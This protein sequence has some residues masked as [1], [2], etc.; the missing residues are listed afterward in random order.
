MSKAAKKNNVVQLRTPD[1]DLVY[2][3]AY[4]SWQAVDTMI[5]RLSGAKK[6][7]AKQWKRDLAEA[8]KAYQADQHHGEKATAAIKGMAREDE[9]QAQIANLR[10]AALECRG[11]AERSK[12]AQA[13]MFDTGAGAS[14]GVPGMSWASPAA[15]QSIYGCLLAI[16][17]GGKPLDTFQSELLV[18]L[19]GVGLERMEFGL[20]ASEAVEADDG[21]EEE[22]PEDDDDPD[23]IGLD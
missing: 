22:P 16:S 10:T 8:K 2:V 1:L 12:S 21:E 11:A 23:D 14:G 4:T 6:R 18:A 7:V 13:D 20:D 3:R 19:G 9:L 5:D 17:E 15:Q